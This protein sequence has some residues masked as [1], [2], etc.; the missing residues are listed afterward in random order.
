VAEREGPFE[1]LI[2]D[3]VMPGMS[4]WVLGKRLSERWPDLRVLYISGYTEDV[5]KD[6]GVVGQG[7]PFLQKP[8][9]PA[10]LLGA[11]RKLL[12]SRV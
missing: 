5:M 9:L 11:V 10:D 7:L 4:G 3:V 1:L 6:G 8:F 12:D 2:T